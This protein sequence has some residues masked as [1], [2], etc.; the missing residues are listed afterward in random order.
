MSGSSTAPGLT[1]I[2]L[3]AQFLRQCHLEES[4]VTLL[5]EASR[6]DY[7]WV[8]LSP[9]T[10]KTIHD[11][12]IHNCLDDTASEVSESFKTDDFDGAEEASSDVHDEDESSDGGVQPKDDNPKL[13]GVTSPAAWSATIDAVDDGVN[14]NST[15]DIS[16]L[17]DEY[18]DDNDCGYCRSAAHPICDVLIPAAVTLPPS[19]SSTTA[20]GR[21]V[22]AGTTTGVCSKLKLQKVFFLPIAARSAAF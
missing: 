5:E 20:F 17:S 21:E 6:L 2:E 15:V 22:R 3:L 4:S 13:W 11:A 7:P 1:L 12:L 10:A 16:A 14:P 19:C 8:Q 18:D 9:S